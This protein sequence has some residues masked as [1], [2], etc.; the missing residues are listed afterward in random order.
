MRV[1]TGLHNLRYSFIAVVALFIAG[2]GGGDGGSNDSTEQPVESKLTFTTVQSAKPGDIVTASVSNSSGESIDLN[3]IKLLADVGQGVTA[4][5]P[6]EPVSSNQISFGAPLGV[7]KNDKF[8]LG[9]GVAKL[10]VIPIES[11]SALKSSDPVNLVVGVSDFPNLNAGDLTKAYLSAT[12]KLLLQSIGNYGLL[13]AKT[14]VIS[15][16]KIS[17][18]TQS[19]NQ[20][21]DY[22]DE[23]IAV[24]DRVQAGESVTFANLQGEDVTLTPASL[25]ILDQYNFSMFQI[26][27]QPISTKNAISRSDLQA[28]IDIADLY[29]I[30]EIVSNLTNNL[31]DFS[32]K[33]KGVISTTLGV[34]GAVALVAGAPEIAAAAAGI[35]AISFFVNTAVPAAISLSLNG[36]SSSILNGS[37]SLEDF[38]NTGAF[39]LN[40]YLEELKSYVTGKSLELALG[41][42][43]GAV[44][45]SGINVVSTASQFIDDDVKS[46]FL[47]GDIPG[48]GYPQ[49]NFSLSCSAQLTGGS[50]YQVVVITNPSTSGANIQMQVSGSDG[51]RLTQNDTTSDGLVTFTV[52]VGESGVRDS[53]NVYD[54]DGRAQSVTTI[55]F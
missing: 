10:S 36:G 40:S 11:S 6:F 55:T 20:Q 32:D 16:D 27:P 4:E 8:E 30:D 52:P 53:I 26:V 50:Y 51:F 13:D 15:E 44:V 41:E 48:S 12:R 22:V 23:M 1:S 2:C 7:L 54:A 18:I 9:S 37:A 3:S 29:N 14:D 25:S 34:V 35:G 38:K 33:N 5:I 47:N 39:V 46:A 19:I 24:I 43:W 21:I 28:K 49:S 45:D 17:S 31:Q 42:K